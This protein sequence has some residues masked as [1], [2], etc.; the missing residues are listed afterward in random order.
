[1]EVILSEQE[2]KSTQQW[3]VVSEISL[4]LIKDLSTSLLQLESTFKA[5]I[6]HLDNV[7]N[8]CRTHDEQVRADERARQFISLHK[9]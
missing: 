5:A 4:R 1:M 9:R 3:D 8:G 6:E 2:D 7:L